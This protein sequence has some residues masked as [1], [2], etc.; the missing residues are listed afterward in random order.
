ME[1]G[2][3]YISVRDSTQKGRIDLEVNELESV[4]VEITTTMGHL[5]LPLSIDHLMQLGHHGT[6][7]KDNI[8]NTDLMLFCLMILMLIC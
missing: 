1:V 6:T 2:F 7:L 8:V 4:C 5:S 3:Y